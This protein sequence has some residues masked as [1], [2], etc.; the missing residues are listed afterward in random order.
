MRQRTAGRRRPLLAK[1][2]ALKPVPAPVAMRASPRE[3][4][5]CNRV[6]RATFAGNFERVLVN[7]SGGTR[8]F[9]SIF[10]DLAILTEER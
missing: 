1:S 10:H 4:A 3:Q 7:K 6:L 9:V 8:M 5:A 2:M